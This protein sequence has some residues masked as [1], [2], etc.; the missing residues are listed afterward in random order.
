VIAAGALLTLFV[1]PGCKAVADQPA[2][3]QCAYPVGP[4]GEQSGDIVPPDLS[5]QGYQDLHPAAGSVSIND[6]LDCDGK[7][8]VRALLVD[9]SAAWCDVCQAT[10]A[11]LD[12]EMSN[13]WHQ[14][15][16][17]VLML[18]TETADRKPA[19]V[20][21]ALEWRQRYGGDGLS[22]VA[23]PGY[24]FR[25]TA[26]A[27]LAPLPFRVLVDPR[28]MAVVDIAVGSTNDYSSVLALADKNADGEK[29]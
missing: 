29:D 7:K 26:G 14:R 2:D 13:G 28:T 12:D 16:I 25:D 5:W 23:D 22:V 11:Q 3:A 20:G 17:R 4:Y 24:S 9:Q 19:T 8:G 6:Y 27:A 18:V 10:A 15:G 1:A 21:T